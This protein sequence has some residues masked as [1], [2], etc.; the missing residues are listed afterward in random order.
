M[1]YLIKNK[2]P[3][4]SIINESKNII[5]FIIIM[6]NQKVQKLFFQMNIINSKDLLYKKL[7]FLI[8]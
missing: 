1:A 7:Y 5:I 4:A 8:I 2:L 3:A 6:S